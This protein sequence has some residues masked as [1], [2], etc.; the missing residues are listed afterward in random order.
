MSMAKHS[1]KESVKNEPDPEMELCDFGNQHLNKSV[2][3]I[4]SGSDEACLASMKQL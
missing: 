3:T 2:L 1:Y 4:L